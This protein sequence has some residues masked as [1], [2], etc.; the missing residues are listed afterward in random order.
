MYIYFVSRLLIYSPFVHPCDIV[1][2]TMSGPPDYRSVPLNKY[3]WRC[4]MAVLHLLRPTQMPEWRCQVG[5]SQGK[6]RWTEKGWW[7][8]PMSCTHLPPT[9]VWVTGTSVRKLR[10]R[11]GGTV[12]NGDGTEKERQRR[13]PRNCR[14]YKANFFVNLRP[15]GLFFLC[16]SCCVRWKSCLRTE[17]PAH[18]FEQSSLEEVRAGSS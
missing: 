16:R 10:D 8:E 18:S 4:H 14:P 1:R 7:Q 5:I 9:S 17:K 11:W 3:L 6:L 15:D 13:N 12:A 2:A